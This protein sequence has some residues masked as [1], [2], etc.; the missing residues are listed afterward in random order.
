MCTLVVVRGARVLGFRGMDGRHSALGF[1]QGQP[2]A[3]S[4]TICRTAI[5][6]LQGR[7]LALAAVAALA[8]THANTQ[9]KR[10]NTRLLAM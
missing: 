10:V 3:T 9:N 6:F 4:V 1:Q 2:P 8:V 5:G 7:P